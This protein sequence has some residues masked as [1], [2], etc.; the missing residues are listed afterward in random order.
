MKL[1][2][3][4]LDSTQAD[5]GYCLI[6]GGGDGRLAAALAERSRLTVEVIEE[7][8]EKIAAGRRFLLGHKLHGGRVNLVKGTPRQLPYPPYNF[9]LVIDLSSLAGAEG[10]KASELVRV[11]RPLG[12]TLVWRGEGKKAPKELQHM[13]EAK[14][15]KTVSAKGFLALRRGKIPG[16]A[17]WSHNYATAGNTYCSE[18]Q[19]V[20]GPFGILWYG[21]PGP[22]QRVDR[23]ARGPVPLVIDGIVFLTGYDLA[24]AYDV[25]NGTKYWERWIPGITRLDLPAGTSN[26]VADSQ[27]LFVVADNKRCLRLDRLTGKTV[28]TYEAPEMDGKPG[29]WGWIARFEDILLGSHSAYDTKRKRAKP[30]LADGL[31]AI[32]PRTGKT[33]WAYHGSGIEHDGVAVD[34]GRVLLGRPESQRRGKKRP[35]WPTG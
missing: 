15:L 26:L 9:N 35:P 14:E 18:D 3:A 19:A 29:N 16:S 23:H 25:Y 30:N 27:S 34:D 32:N 17:N 21:E 10:A 33:L 7:D 5:Q 1:A 6:V 11:T 24:M 28:Q 4:I 13:I 22:R 31:F 20:K 2:E 8:A 12:G